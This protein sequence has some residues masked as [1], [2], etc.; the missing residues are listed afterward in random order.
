MTR[1]IVRPAALVLLLALAVVLALLLTHPGVGGHPSAR[2]LI[3]PK[4]VH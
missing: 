4:I 1:T 2:P 3:M